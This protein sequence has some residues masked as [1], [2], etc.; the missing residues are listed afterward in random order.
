MCKNLGRI[1]DDTKDMGHLA[2]VTLTIRNLEHYL[3]VVAVFEPFLLL[4]Y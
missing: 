3:R 1:W 4:Q 2:Q